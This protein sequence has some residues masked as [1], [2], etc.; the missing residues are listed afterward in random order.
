MSSLSSAPRTRRPWPRPTP[1]PVLPRLGS[2]LDSILTKIG[3]SARLLA[4]RC[5]VFGQ[6]R[7]SCRAGRALP[8]ARSRPI[9]PRPAPA[10][11]RL[12]PGVVAVRAAAAVAVAVVGELMTAGSAAA[13]DV[14]YG[15]KPNVNFDLRE[16][17]TSGAECS[18]GTSLTGAAIVAVLAVAALAAA[19]KILI[20]RGAARAAAVVGTET[21]PLPGEA[22]KTGE[23]DESGERALSSYLDSVGLGHQGGPA[24]GSPGRPSPPNPPNPPGSAGSPT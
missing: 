15:Y 8:P 3:V 4:A 16:G 22:D 14:S 9:L 11:S 7:R 23:S 12:N 17:L 6:S 1:V 20:D 10:R 18:T 19:L 2:R 13:C 21:G 24:P 5:T